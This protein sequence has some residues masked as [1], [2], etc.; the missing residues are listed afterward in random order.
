M[1]ALK[2]SWPHAP[3]HELATN[4]TFFVTAST[5][6]KAHHFRGTDLLCAASGTS[7]SRVQL[8]LAVG[9]MGC[10]LQPPPFHR[11]FTRRL[12]HRREPRAD[13]KDT[14]R[15]NSG[16]D[17]PSGSSPRTA[18]VV[19]LPRTTVNLC[20]ILFRAIELPTSESG[21]A[22]TCARREPICVVLGGVVRTNRFARAG[23]NH[24]PI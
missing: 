9:S 10:F 23:K 20:E 22:R 18:G 12:A 11:S 16:L 21:E 6:L 3:M 1:P 14:S 24:L 2:P 7:H 15:E 19:Q 5:Y 13:V 17:Q 4:G 8:R